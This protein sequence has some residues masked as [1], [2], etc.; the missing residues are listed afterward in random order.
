LVIDFL[1]LFGGVPGGDY[2][3]VFVEH[4]LAIFDDKRD[5]PSAG[6]PDD[7]ILLRIVITLIFDIRPVQQLIELSEINIPV[8]P[9]SETPPSRPA[10][11]LVLCCDRSFL[12]PP[13][14]LKITG[15]QGEVKPNERNV[16]ESV[17]QAVA[18]VTP[19]SGLLGKPRSLPL[20]VL[21]RSPYSFC[22]YSNRYNSNPHKRRN[23]VTENPFDYETKRDAA[24]R[25][26][27]QVQGQKYSGVIVFFI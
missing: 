17:P 27:S 4:I 22:Y 24:A 11:R 2:P 15:E 3:D 25:A 12:T 9:A 5:E 21:I 8:R 26:P 7:P 13:M 6:K 19:Q 18:S 14:G 20:A 1:L 23:G 10:G 16:V